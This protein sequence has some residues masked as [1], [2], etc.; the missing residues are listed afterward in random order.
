MHS[1]NLHLLV[2]F[3]EMQFFDV[4][5]CSANVNSRLSNTKYLVTKILSLHL[6]I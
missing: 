3:L 5:V 4:N 6:V 1:D 2:I